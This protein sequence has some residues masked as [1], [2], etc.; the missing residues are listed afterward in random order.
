M[1]AFQDISKDIFKIGAYGK[2]F[3]FKKNKQGVARIAFHNAARNGEFIKMSE[4]S[5]ITLLD[6]DF[7]KLLKTI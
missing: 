4:P 5:V 2:Y 7:L 1:L 3:L 6:N